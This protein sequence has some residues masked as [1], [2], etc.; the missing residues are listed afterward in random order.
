MTRIA[1]L[2]DHRIVIDGLKLLLSGDPD[3]AI[4]GEYTHGEDL[5]KGLRENPCDL[6]LTDIMMPE[7]D[8]LEVAL[9]VKEQFP[10][11][12][13][14]AL[15]MNGDGQLADRMIEEAGVWG[16]LLK[17]AGKDEL[18]TALR[19][20]R[21]GQTYFPK[22]I[23]TELHSYRRIRR[24]NEEINLTAREID[25]IRCMAEDLSNREIAERLFISER[26]VETHRK[27]IFR[28][29][30]MHSALSLVEFARKRKLI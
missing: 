3:F 26:T 16:Y 9:R 6:V 22:E 29:T 30:G 11:V 5:L 13:V 27:N 4:T 21:E 14:L 12:R 25:I 24:E 15:S 18:L 7:M 20:V 2:D 23:L 17:T 1:I 8:G 10:S 28:K 19:A